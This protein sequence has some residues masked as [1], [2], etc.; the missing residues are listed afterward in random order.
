MKKKDP[1]YGINILDHQICQVLSG[2]WADQVVFEQ[3]RD[4]VSSK[5]FFIVSDE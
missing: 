1:V 3:R 5:D 4:I 2:T